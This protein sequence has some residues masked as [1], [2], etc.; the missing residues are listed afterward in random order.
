[1]HFFCTHSSVRCFYYTTASTLFQGEALQTYHRQK[2]KWSSA[3]P[4]P[5]HSETRVVFVFVFVFQLCWS[6][7]LGSFFHWTQ[8]NWAHCPI[9]LQRTTVMSTGSSPWWEGVWSEKSKSLSLLFTMS[10]WKFTLTLTVHHRSKR[11]ELP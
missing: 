6:G 3:S 8:W 7:S 4:Q 5:T 2:K 10:S 11:Q 1:M 9:L